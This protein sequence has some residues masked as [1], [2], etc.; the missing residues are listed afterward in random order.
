MHYLNL[1][2]FTNIIYLHYNFLIMLVPFL[3]SLFPTIDKLI[4][5]ISRTTDIWIHISVWQRHRA[6]ETCHFLFLQHNIYFFWWPLI[7]RNKDIDDSVK[8]TDEL[9]WMRSSCHGGSY[10]KSLTC[11]LHFII[12]WW[13]DMQT[14]CSWVVV[15]VSVPAGDASARRLYI[16]GLLSD[17]QANVSRVEWLRVTEVFQ[18]Q[19][20]FFY[21]STSN[22]L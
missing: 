20:V 21:L 19:V 11:E 3:F 14:E 7:Q 4:V 12:D 15:S 16:P 5:I 1:V 6:A 2:Y 22:W 18:A 10:L 9:T 17:L 13:S 8:Q